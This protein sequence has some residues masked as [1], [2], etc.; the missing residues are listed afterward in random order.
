MIKYGGEQERKAPEPRA[1]AKRRSYV[2]S[3]AS[4]VVRSLVVTHSHRGLGARNPRNPVDTNLRSP[5]A[6][7]KSLKVMS[8]SLKVTPKSPAAT[9]RS[10]KDTK[11][12]LR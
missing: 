4:S 12:S 11:K 1:P 10:L 7:K 8:W 5:V 2:R 6:T 9:R 3:L